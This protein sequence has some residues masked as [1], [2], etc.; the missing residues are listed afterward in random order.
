MA[1]LEQ[2]KPAAVEPQ[3]AASEPKPAVAEPN[4]QYVEETVTVGVQF[5]EDQFRGLKAE[6]ERIADGKDGITRADMEKAFERAGKELGI[7]STKE[8]RDATFNAMDLDGNGVVDL[9]EFIYDEAQNIAQMQQDAVD[10]EFIEMDANGDGQISFGEFR[11]Q[12]LIESGNIPKTDE[13]KSDGNTMTVGIG[14]SDEEWDGLLT[15]FAQIAKGKKGITRADMEVAFE[16]TAKI[17]NI[18]STKEQRDATFEMMDENGDGV[19]DVDEFIRDRARGIA[20]AQQQEITQEFHQMSGGGEK[21]THDDFVAAK[22]APEEEMLELDVQFSPDGWDMLIESFVKIAKGKDKIT[23]ADLEVAFNECAK[24]LK[25]E[26]SKAARDATFAAMDVNG[27]GEIDFDEF[28]MD[29]AGEIAKDALLDATDDVEKMDTKGDGK[30]S[31]QDFKRAFGKGE[32]PTAQPENAG[33]APKIENTT[34]APEQTEA[35]AKVKHVARTKPD[36]SV[37]DVRDDGTGLCIMP[38]WS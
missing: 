23:R 13:Q 10:N 12:K 11:D 17:L 21:I 6:F 2:P 9:N 18:P 19:I 1:A 28:I 5:T 36:P 30:I 20:M 34:A 29:R 15:R 4:V 7:K 33:A 35:G 3:P 27:D 37:E 25:V 31:Y 22:T 8:E 38:C 14:F 16:Q 24:E 26:S 32:K